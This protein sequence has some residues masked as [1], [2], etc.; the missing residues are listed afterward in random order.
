M[1]TINVD[2]ELQQRLWRLS[3][4]LVLWLGSYT[5]I[6][7]RIAIDHKLMQ[8]DIVRCAIALLERVEAQSE[9]RQQAIHKRDRRELVLGGAVLRYFRVECEWSC[10]NVVRRMRK[11]R[12]KVEYYIKL[13]TK[14]LEPG[15]NVLRRERNH[16]EGHNPN[17]VV[18]K[19]KADLLDSRT[20]IGFFASDSSLLSVGPGKTA[21]GAMI[22]LS[23]F[24]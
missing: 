17:A 5:R 9:N 24:T 23:L 12:V 7:T 14:R 22:D 16:S 6:V 13:P 2:C 11:R 19:R 4:I 18:A 20:R 8:G 21:D 1:L 10:N 3:R 15:P